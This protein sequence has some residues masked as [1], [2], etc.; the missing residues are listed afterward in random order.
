MPCSV[1]PTLYAKWCVYIFID[2]LCVCVHVISHLRITTSRFDTLIARSNAI[3]N[4]VTE[5]EYQKF[6]ISNWDTEIETDQSDCIQPYC[7]FAMC[8]PK[9]IVFIIYFHISLYSRTYGASRTNS[10]HL[11]C[12]IFYVILF[13]IQCTLFV[14]HHNQIAVFISTFAHLLGNESEIYSNL[15]L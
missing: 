10:M 11:W 6:S 5:T 2:L 7:E 3:T 4:I 1:C 8:T 9:F 14:C 13:Y 15:R 12:K